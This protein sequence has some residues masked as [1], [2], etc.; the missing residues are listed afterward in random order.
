M[1]RADKRRPWSHS[2]D[3]RKLIQVSVANKERPM[4]GRKFENL[5][6]LSICSSSTD[7]FCLGRLPGRRWREAVREEWFLPREHTQ[8]SSWEERGTMW[9][10][11]HQPLA[12]AYIPP[13]LWLVW[14]TFWYQQGSVTGVVHCLA[15]TGCCDWYGPL[16]GLKRMLWLVRSTAWH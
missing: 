16:H 6:L 12:A 15:F 10:W 4:S 9:S 13:M 3:S 8:R 11:I 2:V 1:Q 14:P 7:L 5:P